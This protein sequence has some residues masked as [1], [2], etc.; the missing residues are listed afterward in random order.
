MSDEDNELPEPPPGFRFITPEIQAEM[1]QRAMAQAT[2]MG[3]SVHS[4]FESLKPEQM[5]TL[6]RMFNICV[7][8]KKLMLPTYWAGQL[9]AVLRYK[10][11]ICSCCGNP[12][13]DELDISKFVGSEEAAT[14]EV[15][16]VEGPEIEESSVEQM[17]RYNV[18]SIQPGDPSVECNKCSTYFP[19]LEARMESGLK[20][21]VCLLGERFG[22]AD[23]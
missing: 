20:C 10:H 16:K 14:E 11:G 1:Q 21:P 12:L 22:K 17:L 13:H 9:H 2:E 3:L 19:S 4:L 7:G 15:A 6:M 8:N 5:H 23:S 18:S